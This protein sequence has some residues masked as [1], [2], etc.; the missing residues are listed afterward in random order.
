MTDGRL[1]INSG[2][3]ALNNKIAFV[4]IYPDI[5]VPPVIAT[6]PRSSTNEEFRAVSL[7]VTLSQGS[8]TLFYQ[9]YFNNNPLLGANSATLSFPHIR[10]A[11]AGAYYLIVTNFGGSATSAVATVAVT[12][13]TTPPSIASVGSL[14]GLSI[15]VR[16]NEELDPVNLGDLGNYTVNGGNVNVTTVIVRPDG[17]SVKL[18]LDAPITGLFR[19]NA[20]SSLDLADNTADSEGSN[21]VVGFTTGDVGS[22]ALAGANYTDDGINLELVGGGADYWNTNDMAYLA[23]RT[24]SGNFDARVRVTL[25]KGANA[26]TKAVLCQRMRSWRASIIRPV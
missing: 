9:W 19:V 6:S 7:A 2:P 23:T 4:D 22:P 26:I 13:D 24:V 16:F 8:P 18:L 15:G 11:D 14:D 3:G 10:A 21:I 20:F 17:R 5:P 12:P 1:T 25:L